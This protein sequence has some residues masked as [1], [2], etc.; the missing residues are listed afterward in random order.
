LSL[1]AKL[2]KE[3]EELAAKKKKSM[4]A[5]GDVGQAKEFGVLGSLKFALPRLYAGGFWSKFIFF[6]NF[7]LIFLA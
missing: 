1:S 4:N 7:L 5:W 6:I 2:K 3:E